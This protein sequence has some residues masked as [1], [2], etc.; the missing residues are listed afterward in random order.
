MLAAQLAAEADARQPNEQSQEVL[1]TALARLR[2][3]GPLPRGTFDDL[4]KDGTS[5]LTWGSGGAFLWQLPSRRLLA[6]VS[7]GGYGVFAQA[8]SSPQAGQFA[9]FGTTAGT[10]AVLDPAT[11]HTVRVIPTGLQ[12]IS[13]IAAASSVPLVV[14]SDGSNCAIADVATGQVISKIGVCFLPEISPH[15]TAV[16]Y[17]PGGLGGTQLLVLNRTTG[18]TVASDGAVLATVTGSSLSTFSCAVCGDPS[19]LLPDARALIPQGLSPA[20]Q[21][22]CLAGEPAEFK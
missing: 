21:A 22:T 9:V 20:E 4:S 11:G 1:R 2:E 18:R 13:Y 3:I 5:A 10:L 16:S 7:R 8:A 14:A 12:S 6:T 15:G 19:L 17:F